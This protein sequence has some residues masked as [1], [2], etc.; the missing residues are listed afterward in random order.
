M[1][2]IL[3]SEQEQLN[4]SEHLKEKSK[5]AFEQSLAALLGLRGHGH[6]LAVIHT[7]KMQPPP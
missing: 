7:H 4:S 1:S 3:N 2:A 6:G 5:K